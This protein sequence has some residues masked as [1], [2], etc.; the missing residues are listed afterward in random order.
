MARSPVESIRN[1]RALAA[2]TTYPA[3]A[4]AASAKAE[5]LQ[6]KYGVDEEVLTA[7][8]PPGA[9]PRSRPAAPAAPEPW[10]TGYIIFTAAGGG[11]ASSQTVVFSGFTIRIF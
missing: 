3:E 11:N 8:A 9:P 7:T 5:E 6:A 10:P 1:L 4:A 2:G